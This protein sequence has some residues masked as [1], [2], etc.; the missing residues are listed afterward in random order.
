MA[1]VAFSWRTLFGIMRFNHILYVVLVQGATTTNRI[2]VLSIEASQDRS[3]KLAGKK[4]HSF[5]VLTRRL[6]VG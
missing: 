1:M 4:N 6:V 2:S 5:C 3:R